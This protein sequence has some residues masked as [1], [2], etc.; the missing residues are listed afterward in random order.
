MYLEKKI[1]S[2]MITHFLN[3][4]SPVVSDLEIR[5]LDPMISMNEKTLEG[6]ALYLKDEI[7][8][9]S[10]NFEMVQAYYNRFINIFTDEILNRKELKEILKEVEIGIE[11][12]FRKIND[13]YRNTMCLI[14]YFG[15]IQI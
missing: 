13:M 12:K 14:S 15:K 8:E 5:S 11:N 1:N 9:S 2:E 3:K 6:F 7:I 4:L 10:T